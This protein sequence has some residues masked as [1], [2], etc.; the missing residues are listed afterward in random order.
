MSTAKLRIMGNITTK[1]P[2]GDIDYQKALLI[3]FDSDE[4]IRT[5]LKDMK[6]EFVWED[7]TKDSEQQQ[8]FSQ[9]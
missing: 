4:D 3:E 2:D 5:A 8:L 1:E 9:G 6:C 7:N